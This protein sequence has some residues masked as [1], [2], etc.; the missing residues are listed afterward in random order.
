MSKKRRKSCE[1]CEVHCEKQCEK[2]CHK[3]HINCSLP[4]NIRQLLCLLSKDDCDTTA[5]LVLHTCC[6][7]ECVLEDV[8]IVA[9]FDDTVVIR[10]DCKFSYINIC[11]ICEV[12][13][14]CDDILDELLESCSK[15]CCIKD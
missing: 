5:T 14:D 2:E 11:C 9:V 6:C 7:E 3:S 8:K 12:K 13:I 4:S 1:Q 15:G 10:C